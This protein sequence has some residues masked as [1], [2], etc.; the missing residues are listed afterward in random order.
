MSNNSTT[1]YAVLHIQRGSGNDSGMST[2][3][4]RKT[5][6]GK[7]YVPDNADARRTLLNRELVRFPKGVHTRSDAIQH[8]IDNTGLHRKVGSNQTKVLRIILTGSHEQM[9]EIERMGK[10]NDWTDVN[11]RWLK[12]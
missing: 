6:D 2:H 1:Q 3:I 10:L 5:A 8:R 9:M 12:D 7:V 4:E 11:L